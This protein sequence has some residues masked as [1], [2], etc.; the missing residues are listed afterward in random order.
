MKRIIVC[1]L[2]SFA[3]SICAE[4]QTYDEQYVKCSEPLKALGTDNDSLYFA[5]LRDRDSCLRG[6]VAPNFK[7]TSVSGEQIELAN[8]KGQVVVL[9]FWF[10][11]CPPC[12]QEM[13]ALN[14]LVDHY[15]GRKIKFVSFAP[16]NAQSLDSFFKQHPFKFAAI[17]ESEN[18][19]RETF[20]LFPAWPYTIIIDREGKISRMWP[21]NP[22]EHVFSYYQEIIDKLL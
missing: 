5:R 14:R 18:I 13:P 11:K 1:F 22:G 20:K 21:G 4:A 10:T 8:L 6:T 3:F 17:A 7:A 9:N 16:E 12:I 15:A 19:R 2:I